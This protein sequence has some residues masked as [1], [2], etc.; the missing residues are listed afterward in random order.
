MPLSSV[1]FIVRRA[2]FIRVSLCPLLMCVWITLYLSDDWSRAQVLTEVNRA[3]IDRRGTTVIP[4]SEIAFEGVEVQTPEG[5][6]L[7]NDLSF[8]VTPG[9]NLLVTGCV[10]FFCLVT[11]ESVD[12]VTLCS[13]N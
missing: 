3:A 7:I 8:R 12:V 2:S 6:T 4:G 11:I 9:T 5:V 10:V 13:L 1:C